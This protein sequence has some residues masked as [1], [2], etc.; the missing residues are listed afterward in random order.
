MKI[1]G[2]KLTGL[3]QFMSGVSYT[4]NDIILY[5]NRFYVVTGNEYD[6][7]LT[8]DKSKDCMDYVEY[9]SFGSGKGSPLSIITSKSVYG[10]IKKYFKGL[11]GNGEIDT[12]EINSTTDLDKY[13]ETGAYRCIIRKGFIGLIPPS[14]YLLRVYKTKT[15]TIQEFIDYNTG[16]F[17]VRN[18]EDG[19]VFV[20]P[21]SDPEN[22]DRISSA[23]Q[24]INN[25]IKEII[26]LTDKMNKSTFNFQ[27]VPFIKSG[28]KKYII[29]ETEADQIMHLIF[30][31]V[32]GDEY[33]QYSKEI[34]LTNLSRNVKIYFDELNYLTATFDG[35]E[36][37]INVT[38]SNIQLF[39]AYISRGNA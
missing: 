21:S 6:G 33:I 2:S 3:F 9:N 36:L 31:D 23:I 19:K 15:N 22:Q 13:N 29:R 20:L 32:K 17:V 35:L 10:I 25:R 24:N 14:E 12:V 37:T 7:K 26:G 1:K 38:D 18:M 30:L 4:K 27:N 5:N 16:L 8:P 28:E 11:T 34:Y 39:K